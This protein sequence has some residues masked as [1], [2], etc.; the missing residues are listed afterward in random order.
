MVGSGVKGEFEDIAQFV[1]F[2]GK[3][4]ERPSPSLLLSSPSLSDSTFLQSH[5]ASEP[6][7]P[8][9]PS[10]DIDTKLQ[11]L[12]A[13]CRPLTRVHIPTSQANVDLLLNDVTEKLQY[14]KEGRNVL[15]A[16][17]LLGFLKEYSQER[18]RIL[19]K[20]A[21]KQAFS[22]I[23]QVTK[24]TKGSFSPIKT[25]KKPRSISNKAIVRRLRPGLKLN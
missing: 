12:L 18:G 16:K 2:G 5:P 15:K 24:R 10:T 4:E 9:T 3:L 21:E 25:S 11:E 7:V 6:P 19:A 22:P 13:L 8:P 17:M 20:T 23:P 1:V 14:V